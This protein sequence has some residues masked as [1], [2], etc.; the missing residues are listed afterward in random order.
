MTGVFSPTNIS[1]TNLTVGTLLS[2]TL[3][4]TTNLRATTITTTTLLATGNSNTI[5]SLFTTGG[6][7]GINTTA[8]VSRLTIN[9]IVVKRNG[10]DHSGAP[11]TI[12][13]PTASGSTLNDKLPVL[14]LCRQ[15]SSSFGTESAGQRATFALSRYEDNSGLEGSRT[16]MDIQMPHDNQYN[17]AVDVMSIRSD[18]RVGIGT[19]T[20]TSPLHVVSRIFVGNGASEPTGS[21]L[22]YDSINDKNIIQSS[23]PGHAWKRLD[24]NC[25]SYHLTE[26]SD[27][28]LKTNIKDY[29]ED[30]Y[31][32]FKSVK[33]KKYN[34]RDSKNKIDYGYLAQDLQKVFPDLIVNRPEIDEFLGVETHGLLMRL[35]PL[36]QKFIEK[37][38]I[39]TDEIDKLKNDIKELKKL[40]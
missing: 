33:Y 35:F 26:Y 29:D 30:V 6:N 40:K 12:T 11:L 18:G 3:I 9:N 24:V 16:R 13:H 15:G 32:K 17:V 37:I 28:R 27:E 20:P 5:G 8:P 25:H 14:H 10:F 22:I 2:G 4:S 38:D 23:K 1:T 7:V 36:S 39:L 19:T 31:E 34:L 21:E